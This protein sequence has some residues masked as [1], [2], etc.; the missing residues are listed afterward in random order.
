MALERRDRWSFLVLEHLRNVRL[1]SGLL[2]A[3]VITMEG[4]SMRPLS[5]TESTTPLKQ[6]SG[7][8]TDKHAGQ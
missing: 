7:A 5:A 8:Q 1:G 6:K 4:K 2:E 3:R